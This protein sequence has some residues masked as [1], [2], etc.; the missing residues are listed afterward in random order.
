MQ[1]AGVDNST[2]LSPYLAAGCLSPRMVLEELQL[3]Q[4]AA[5]QHGVPEAECGWLHM[6]LCIRDFF[7]FT[8]LKEDRSMMSAAG[9]KGQPLQWGSEPGTFARWVAL[10][11]AGPGR[12]AAGRRRR[13]GLPYA[14][15]ARLLRPQAK[16]QACP[17]PPLTLPG[18]RPAALGCLSWTR[19]CGNWRAAAT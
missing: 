19:A 3:L 18:G 13:R 4:A 2:K 11:R 12:P 8:A 9:I 7:T 5:Q 1:A 6:H 10:G 15:Q 14:L 16:P 17:P